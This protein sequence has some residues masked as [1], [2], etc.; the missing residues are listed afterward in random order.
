VIQR[1]PQY[2]ERKFALLCS[3]AGA[4]A[5]KAEEDEGG[6]DFLVEFPQ[7]ERAGPADTH[8]PAPCAYVQVKSKASKSLTCRIKLSNALKAAQSRQPWFFVLIVSDNKQ[9]TRTYAMHVWSDL[10]RTILEKVRKAENAN[11]PLHRTS[12]TLNFAE[13]HE[14]W[15]ALINWMQQTIEALGDGYEDTKKKLHQTLG[16]EDNC[17]TG[18]VTV[19][20][21]NADEIAE[22]F[23]GLGTGLKLTKF[24]YTASRFGIPD[25]TPQISSTEVGR[26]VVTP[27]PVGDC[28][29]RVSS[30]HGHLSLPGKVFAFALP[31]MPLEQRRLRFS[32][33]FLDVI[34]TGAANNL[35]FKL[36]LDLN[37]EADLLT[38]WQQCAVRA[39]VG[40]GQ[41]D[42]QVWS[43]GKR[44]LAGGVSGDATDLHN[45]WFEIASFIDFL[46]RVAGE[47]QSKVK[48]SLA[49]IASVTRAQRLF[50]TFNDDANLQLEFIPY[51]T[52][53][54]R[55]SSL[56]YY[57]Q[58][59]IG[60]W[61]FCALARRQVLRDELL[62]D[63]KRQITCGKPTFVDAYVLEKP[64]AEQ[65]KM[66]KADYERY[67]AKCE[68]EESALGLRDI[69][70]LQG[71][72][73]A[74]E[75]R[76]FTAD[77][78]DQKQAS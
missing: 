62:A 58:S 24:S 64:T 41:V 61:S 72:L 52:A 60:D 1:L 65:Q 50:Q 44:M 76:A 2:A 16:Y 69:I 49:T 51:E 3:A 77:I 21:N 45:R 46:R 42:L 27:T 33:S 35:K 63:G 17:G 28:E 66:I 74:S 15:D 20:A 54:T 25:P 22:G 37:A 59:A 47:T 34:G 18:V 70:A 32:A 23:L 7:N 73:S 40:K 13:A 31:E 30:S 11:Q 26:L 38:L 53:P 67:F 56:I 39:W 57:S 78:P 10:M 29:I 75:L 8:P 71:S 19:E 4:R 68:H 6:W 36:N 43:D 12:I 9:R 5:H 14:R 48:V 55:V